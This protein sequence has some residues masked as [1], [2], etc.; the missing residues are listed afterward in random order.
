M[1]WD[2]EREV[3]W[4]GGEAGQLYRVDVTARTWVEETRAPGFVLGLAVDA[5]GRVVA[6]CAAEGVHAWDGERWTEITREPVFANYPAFGPDGT[7]YVSDSGSGW[8]RNDG[9]ILRIDAG[10]SVDE[11]TREPAAF[12][13]GLCVDG[14]SLLCVES[15]DP[16]LSRVELAT[17]HLERIR[18]FEG[19]VLDGLAPTAEGGLLVACYRPDRIYHLDGDGAL[20]IA[21]EDPQGTLLAAPTN[22]CFVGADLDRAVSANLGRWHLTA[23]EPGVRGRPLHRPERWALDTR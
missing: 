21:A 6:C 17:G 10:G 16:W 3:L 20:S 11:L 23:F 18:R 14:N 8:G 5:L 9:R 19:D 13:N 22:V 1:A 2:P 4:A 7:L 12:T 15:Y